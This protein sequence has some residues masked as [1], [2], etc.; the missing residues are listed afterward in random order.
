MGHESRLA[1]FHDV[2]FTTTTP[3]EAKTLDVA[4]DH[5]TTNLEA[6]YDAGAR[7]FVACGNTGEYYSLTDDERAAV[8]RTHVEAV[9]S[10]GLVVGSAGGSVRSVIDLVRRYE[11]AG[12]DAAMV[13]HPDHTHVHEEGLVEYYHRIAAGTDADLV[14]YKRG[15]EISH[16]VL[17]RIAAIDDV[18]AIKYAVNDI[19]AFSK[20][21]ANIDDVAWINGIA[22]RFA[23]SFALEGAGGYTTGLGNFAPVATLELHEAIQNRDWGRATRLRE[24]LRSFEDLR[25][26]SG[27]A[28]QFASALNVPAVKHAMDARDLYGGPVRDP[29]VDLSDEERRRAEKYADQIHS[30]TSGG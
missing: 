19:K 25:E 3:F 18:V 23:P 5:L 8:V 14:V 1:R 10:D 16:G 26:E 4:H 7:L 17:S 6:L 30:E 9:G 29:L 24:L 20:A 22:E 2:A 13:M 21:T 28:N 12:V 15:P 11:K 27:E